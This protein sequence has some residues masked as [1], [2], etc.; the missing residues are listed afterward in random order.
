[1]KASA[2]P[3]SARRQQN[4]VAPVRG[5]GIRPKFGR[6]TRWR[7]LWS[8]MTG[9]P[10]FQNRQPE[11]QPE[12]ERVEPGPGGWFSEFIAR[13][14]SPPAK[15]CSLSRPTS[16]ASASCTLVCS[17]RW[18]CSRVCTF[19]NACRGGVSRRTGLGTGNSGNFSRLPPAARVR[20]PH[21]AQPPL[22]EQQRLRPAGGDIPPRWPR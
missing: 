19:S 6:R 4:P 3:A 14:G 11:K 22:H 1:M 8:R 12:P 18:V 10:N 7:D 20:S 2:A 21:V 15:K 13:P 16:S 9:L 5:P 17:N